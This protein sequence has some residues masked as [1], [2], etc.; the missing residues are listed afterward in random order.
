MR[1]VARLFQLLTLGVGL[2]AGGVSV[3]EDLTP[4][5]AE[6]KV[7]ISVL[8]GK[9]NTR[10]VKTDSGYEA[11]HRVVPAGMSKMFVRGAIEEISGFEATEDGVLPLRYSSNDTL[12]RDKTRA[13]VTFDWSTGA[14]SGTVN[15]EKIESVLEDIAHDRVSI[16]YELMY[17]MLNGGASG[18][19]TMFDID[20]LKTINVTL[21]GSKK[22][23]VPAGR[24][25][26]VGVQ[27]QTV[28]SSRTTT[29]WC[30]EELDFL[31]VIIE[32]HRKGKLKMRAK[33][34]KYSPEAT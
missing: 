7:R 2:A 14:I 15:D 8:S 5:S 25:D 18:T 11:N 32:Q 23:K 31:P 4:H 12:S 9:L 13:D 17:D 20:R 10:L 1:N 30:V 24:F 34:T 16:Q 26:A 28:G 29:L 19:Y 21:I 3:A 27:H 33:L 6:Y 22:I